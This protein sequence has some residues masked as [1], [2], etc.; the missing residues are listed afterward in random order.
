MKVIYAD[1]VL[2]L[3]QYIYFSAAVGKARGTYG[4]KAPAV[5]GNEIFERYYR[6]QMNTLEL[7]ICL[8]PALLIAAQ[9]WSPLVM[10]AI[11]FLFFIG[12]LIYFRS[13]IANPD[14]RTIGFMLSITPIFILLI[15][16]IIGLF[17]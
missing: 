6:V 9:F 2:V 17:I 3:F 13:Y 16:I 8:I 1:I 14:K 4:I 15:A 12:R 7:L 11:G 5:T 10:A